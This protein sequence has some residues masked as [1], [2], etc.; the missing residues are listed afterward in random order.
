MRP[1][2]SYAWAT[3]ARTLRFAVVVPLTAL[4]LHLVRPE[5]S[6][7]S[8]CG[9]CAL[10]LLLLWFVDGCVAYSRSW[11]KRRSTTARLGGAGD[12]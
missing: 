4:T 10:S 7:W 9:V 1:R 12:R 5:I 8:F 11:K 3:V 2:R 6:W